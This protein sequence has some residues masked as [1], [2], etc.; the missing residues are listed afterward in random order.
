MFKKPSTLG[1]SNVTVPVFGILVPI[2]MIRE[3]HSIMKSDPKS[4]LAML[5]PNNEDIEKEKFKNYWNNFATKGKVYN[6]R[7]N[8]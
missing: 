5:R 7:F 3:S 2:N 6:P 8:Y 4:N 1:E